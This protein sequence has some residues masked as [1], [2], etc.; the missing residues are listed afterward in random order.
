[1]L[2]KSNDLK[3]ALAYEKYDIGTF[4]NSTRDNLCERVRGHAATS[5]QV[6]QSDPDRPG[7]ARRLCTHLASI[8]RARRDRRINHRRQEA[9]APC[10]GQ[11]PEAAIGR[12]FKALDP[13]MPVRSAGA[14]G[15]WPTTISSRSASI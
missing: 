2:K 11:S 3:S 7:T 10:G 15:C 5:Y 4:L 9:N 12:H 8:D 6:Y 14:G 13:G 1:M